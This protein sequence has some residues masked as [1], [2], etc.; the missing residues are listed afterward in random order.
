MQ[1][2]LFSVAAKKAV[3]TAAK[4]IVAL[5]VSAKAT[6]LEKKFGIKIDTQTFELAVGSAL[7]AIEHDAHMWLKQKYP[8]VAWL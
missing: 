1:Q 2:Y 7:F 4:A 3:L 8:N 5:V 6:A